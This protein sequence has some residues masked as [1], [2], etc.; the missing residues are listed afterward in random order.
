MAKREDKNQD[1][2]FPDQKIIVSPLTEEMEGSF[3]DYAMSVIVARALPDARDGLKPVHRRILYSMYES[4]LTYDKP[5][6]KAA[7]AV[8][9][10]MG[11]YHPHGDASIYDALVRLAQDFSMRYQLISGHG[12]FGSVDGDPAAAMRYTEA[13]LAR[14]SDELL[15]DIE[16][17]TV[18]W[19]PNY[20]ETRKEPR[21]L[22]SRFPNLLVNGSSGIA[23]GMTTNI[24]PH[25]LTEVI[26]AAICVLKNDGADLNDLMEHIKGPDFP[27]R[28]VIMGRVG[29]RA[30]YATGRGRVVLRARTELEEF[31]Q[32]RTAIIV[33]ELPY[34]VNKKHLIENIAE[35]VKN[36]RLDGISAMRD[37]SDR[38]GMRIVI[39]L[40]RDANAQVV[41]NR[42][43]SMTQLQITFA[44]VMLA[45]VENQT[46]PRIL[47]LRG[48]LDEYLAHQREVI[49]RRTEYD[50]RKA[51]ERAHL[52][53]GLRIA[54]DNI[55]E[56]I[57]IIRSSYDDAR[58]R[59]MERFGLSEVQ[60]QAILEMQLRRLQGLEREK[61]EAEYTALQEKISYYLELLG[62]ARKLTQ[63]LITELEEI[64]DKYGDERK[65][66][67]A[68]VEDEIDIE[69]LIDEEECVYTLTNAGYIKRQPASTYRAQ[70]RGGRGITAMTTREEDYVENLLSASTHDYILFFTNRGR[71]F[72]RKGYQI[73]EAGR[74]AKGTNIINLI[75][76]EGGEGGE[77]V[78][79]MIRARMEEASYLIF[80]TRRGTVKRM[81]ATELR[82]IKNV[83]IRA[84]NLAPDDELISV[85]DTDGRENILIA[86]HDGMAIC[87][88]ESDLR[89]MGRAAAGV[90]GIRLRG[91]DYCVGAA[92]A[93]DGGTLLTVTENGYGKRTEISAYLR[94]GDGGAEFSAQGRGGIGRR[95]CTITEKTGKVADIKVVDDNDDVLII[96]DDGTVI[97][98]AASAI[99]LYGRAA[100]GVRLMRLGEGAKVIALARTD[101][102][103][104]EE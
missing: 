45:L 66:D 2:S 92:R 102:E 62:D 44:I 37:E 73:P 24:P 10:V 85:R 101:K 41:L 27:T 22:P 76:I 11:H 30:A 29:I 59:L 8:G 56:V 55:D 53:E 19:D 104:A 83:G 65:T 100:Q 4:N 51:R 31:G 35:H 21:V 77:R 39:E 103:E 75:P 50:L 43:F 34:Q 17:D 79:A 88:S 14:I 61:V 16:K 12:N 98:M 33:T 6:R 46:Q 93:R 96:S 74:T 71:A 5:F 36:K 32:G 7:T 87:F 40:R 52:L 67:I 80:V 54:V 58:E 28:G 94:G 89:P 70:R 78:T 81:V 42:L 18:D 97:R 86:T 84:V 68:E 91:G 3:I 99:S 95:N 47:S 20:D 26:N 90:R 9:D 64:R 38:N 48:L 15:R 23:V 1:I 25:N 13:R 49:R 82:N 69:D 57:R 63:A 60:A 72:R